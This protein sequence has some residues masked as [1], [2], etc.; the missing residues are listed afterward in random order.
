M[1]FEDN[2]CT[3]GLNLADMKSGLTALLKQ[4]F[5]FCRILR[6]DDDDKPNAAVKGS[7]H[8]VVSNLTFGLQPLEY[9]RAVPGV[10]VDMALKTLRQYAR[11]VAG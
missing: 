2:T 1:L 8:L 11:N 4:S 6:G 7:P 5:H 10:G 3:T 9:F